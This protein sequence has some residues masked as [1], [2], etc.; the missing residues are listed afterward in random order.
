MK[1][2]FLMSNNTTKRICCEGY[3]FLVTD[4]MYFSHCLKGVPIS[5]LNMQSPAFGMN[6]A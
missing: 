2:I 3:Y 5:F 1:L 6:T 4:F